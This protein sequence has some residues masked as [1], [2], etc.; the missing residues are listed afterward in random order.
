ML[1]DTQHVDI[2]PNL[3]GIYDF[4]HWGAMVQ[5]G[6]V[7]GRFCQYVIIL[8]TKPLKILKKGGL[9]IVTT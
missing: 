6:F 7:L 4:H 3:T 8:K 9:V 1:F 2:S 5:G